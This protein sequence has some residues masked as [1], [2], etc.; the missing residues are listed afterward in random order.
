MIKKIIILGRNFAKEMNRNHV[1]AYASSC[2]FFLFLSLI[3]ILLLIF[4]VLPYTPLTSEN[5]VFYLDEILPKYL[6]PIID[7]FVFE[8][9]DKSFTLVS[10]TAIGALWSAGKGILALIRGLNTV[11]AV[12]ESRNYFFL[13][14]QS[15]VYT[16]IMLLSVLLSLMI[17]VFGQYIVNV[18]VSYVPQVQYF[19]EFLLSIRHV[20]TIVIL[21]MV[22][23]AIFTWLP[24]GKVSWRHQIP[25]AIVVGVGWTG[26]SMAFSFYVGHFSGFSMYGSLST[27]IIVMLWLYIC[28]YIVLIGALL[29]KFL[30]PATDFLWGKRRQQKQEEQIQENS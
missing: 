19:L 3:P 26:F 11:N 17:I 29:N 14:I 21:E 24:S 4:A 13:R 23:V 5:L 7:S 27:V 10:V 16:L 6:A 28:M 22:F 30:E 18:V 25:G 15:S 12:K 2:A 1:S 8:V 20:F 9:Y